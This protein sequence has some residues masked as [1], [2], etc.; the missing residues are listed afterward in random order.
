MRHDATSISRPA[1]LGRLNPSSHCGVVH[2]GRPARAC[3]CR[4][5]TTQP[6]SS[7][8]LGSSSGRKH[9][10]ILEGIEPGTRLFHRSP[11]GPNMPTGTRRTADCFRLCYWL[12]SFSQK[13]TAGGQ[14]AAAAW[15]V[16]EGLRAGHGC[17]ARPCIQRRLASRTIASR[18]QCDQLWRSER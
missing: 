16:A 2:R 1:P 9:P 7:V 5:R 12:F 13:F 14:D 8:T 4:Q 10:R 17:I 11:P 18:N 3:W 15:P 6:T